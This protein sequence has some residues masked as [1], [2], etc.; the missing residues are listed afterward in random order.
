[1]LSHVNLVARS[2]AFWH[3]Q[4]VHPQDEGHVTHQT[5]FVIDAVQQQKCNNNGFHSL[6]THRTPA[7][8]PGLGYLT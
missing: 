8:F 3:E 2:L 4:H 6:S 7:T 1:M 5:W